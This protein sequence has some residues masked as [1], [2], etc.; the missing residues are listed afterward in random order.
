MLYGQRVLSVNPALHIERNGKLALIHGHSS[1]FS[2]NAV[3]V[4]KSIPW[5]PLSTAKTTRCQISQSVK[6]NHM[7]R[8]PGS[9]VYL[10]CQREYRRCLLCRCEP[11]RFSVPEV[12][13]HIE[14][15]IKIQQFRRYSRNENTKYCERLRVVPRRPKS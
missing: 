7:A 3:L 8:S 15:S 4:A 2:V 12:R 10:R 1:V 14:I 11:D 6:L 9:V 13:M 5:I